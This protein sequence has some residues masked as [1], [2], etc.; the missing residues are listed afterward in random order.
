M[1]FSIYNC[2]LNINGIFRG[3]KADEECDGTIEH[4][5]NIFCRQEKILIFNIR[6]I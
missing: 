6:N 3:F 5:T 2:G 1:Q 4:E